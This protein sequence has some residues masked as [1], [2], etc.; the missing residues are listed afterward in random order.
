YNFVIGHSKRGI[1]GFNMEIH[2]SRLCQCGCGQY[3]TKFRGRH[4]RFMRKH[5]N[6][7]RVP[8]NKGKAFS[9]EV[10]KK[11]S[12]AR[13]GKEPANKTVIDLI[14]LHR[15]YIHEKKTISTVSREI[16]I[17]TDA[18]KNRLRA[19]G[20]SRTTKE[21]C[22]TDAF[23]EQMRQ[24]RIKT[25]TS[26]QAIES[27]NK[28]EKSVYEALDRMNI[29]YEKQ[30]PLFGKFV[31]DVLFPQQHLV[32]EI[33]GRYWHRMPQNVRKNYSK[34]KYLEKC[35]YRVE[36]VW[37]N[38]IKEKGVDSVLEKVVEKYALI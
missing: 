31:V 17:L 2:R 11:M 36:E 23:R 24:I 16:N 5:E 7:G 34:K 4:N 28:L 38:E 32:L 29:P 37:D 30:V 20:W 9:D 35:G 14:A 27:P 12:L 3:T 26:R 21:S 15:H 25:L 18:I 8:W 13:L 22:A 33:F 10:R 1:N 19:L 6:N